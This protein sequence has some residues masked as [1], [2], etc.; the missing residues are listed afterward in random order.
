MSVSKFPTR[1]VIH[2]KDV[3]NITGYM[4]RTARNLL[5]KI[6]R[7]VGKPKRSLVTIREFCNYTGIDEELVREFLKR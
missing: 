5:Q 4:P 6:K 1:V 2:S 3:E 7:L